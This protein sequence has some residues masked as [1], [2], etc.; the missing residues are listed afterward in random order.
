MGAGRDKVV[1]ETN[2]SVLDFEGAVAG[3]RELGLGEEA[4][5]ALLSGN[6]RRVYGLRP[7]QPATAV[8]DRATG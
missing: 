6:T 3:A 2:K 1:F 8:D 7:A 4:E 5:R